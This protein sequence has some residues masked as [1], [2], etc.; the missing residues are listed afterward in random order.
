MPCTLAT[1]SV[2]KH[3][4]RIE[5]G[6]RARGFCANVCDSARVPWQ[7]KGVLVW[8]ASTGLCVSVFVRVCAMFVRCCGCLCDVRAL[9]VLRVRLRK[10]QKPTQLVECK[11]HESFPSRVCVAAVAMCAGGFTRAKGVNERSPCAS[12]LLVLKHGLCRCGR[13][14][15]GSKPRTC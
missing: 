14:G 11:R 12:Q 2:H 13:V 15:N 8:D 9:R 4:L 5:K 3:C 7:H 10:E 1:L 6:P